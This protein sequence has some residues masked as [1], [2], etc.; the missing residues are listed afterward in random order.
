MKKTMIIA[1]AA[2]LFSCA[3]VI[4]Q[5]TYVKERYKIK[6]SEIEALYNAGEEGAMI[7]E[8]QNMPTKVASIDIDRDGVAELLFSDDSEED[9]MMVALGTGKPEVVFHTQQKTWLEFY[10]GM[11]KRIS[12]VGTG[13]SLQDYAKIVKSRPAIIVHSEVT[14]PMG[15][16]PSM[17]GAKPI[18]KYTFPKN[19]KKKPLKSFLQE[20]ENPKKY[21]GELKWKSLKD[22]K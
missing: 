18:T 5:K 9:M 17:S 19:V 15:A 8:H 3:T 7:I 10:E 21:R 12:S 2:W 14:W 16:D 13:V 20:I 11:V 22:F 6:M 1:T 4:A